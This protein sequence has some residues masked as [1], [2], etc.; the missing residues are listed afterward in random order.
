MY[1]GFVV[2]AERSRTAPERLDL[3]CTKESARTGS[4]AAVQMGF[5]CTV[6]VCLGLCN[7][8]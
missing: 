2:V 1:T 3:A 6:S 5:A 8:V 4:A 7:G